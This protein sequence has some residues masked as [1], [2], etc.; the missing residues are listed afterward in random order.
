MV[1]IGA[2]TGGGFQSGARACSAPPT[3]TS[4]PNA[5]YAFNQS[6]N[7][8]QLLLQPGTWW[9]SGFVDVFGIGTG[10]NESTTQPVVVTVTPGSRTKEN[11]TVKVA[12]P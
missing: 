3:G 2:P 12:V 11:F 10:V 7:L 6:S 9:V 5:Q 4:C 8:Y 1:V